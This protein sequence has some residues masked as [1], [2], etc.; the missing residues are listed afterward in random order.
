MKNIPLFWYSINKLKQRPNF[1]SKSYFNF[2]FKREKENYGDLLSKYL[3]EKISGKKIRWYRPHLKPERNFFVIGSI[4]NHSDCQSIIWGSGIIDRKHNVEL[5]EVKAVRGPL[6][7]LRL[8]ELSIDCPEVYGDPALLLPRFHQLIKDKKHEIGIVPHYID[9]DLIN[10]LYKKDTN[11]RVINLLTKDIK[12]TT[13]EI[14]ECS[15]IISS[16]LHG[17][18]IAHA[19]GIP[20]IWV[21]YSNNLYGD[22]VKFDDYLLSVNLKPYNEIS[23]QTKLTLE[24]ML[25]LIHQYDNL[26]DQSY[27]KELCDKLLKACPF[28]KSFS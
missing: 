8:L 11:V 2:L 15:Y 14:I 5:A 28:E 9:F 25:D 12:K 7:R 6:T 24:E 4:L 16:S 10:N 22:N 27:I 17:L 18:I 23:I 3:V 19:Y 26:P 13:N 21:K 1:F 20:A